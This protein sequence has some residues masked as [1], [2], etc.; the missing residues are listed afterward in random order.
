MKPLVLPACFAVAA[1]AATAAL[2]NPAQ[3]AA[4]WNKTFE[5]ASKPLLTPGRL[6]LEVTPPKPSL[7]EPSTSP[8]NRRARLHGD[9]SEVLPGWQL[10]PKFL[11]G[12][13]SDTPPPGAKPWYYRGE[14]FWIV[15]IAADAVPDAA[16]GK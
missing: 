7:V 11:H 6:G 2:T 15:P 10:D 3:V 4:E 12:K 9:V 16:P 5:E 13:Q 8:G 1:V 14:K